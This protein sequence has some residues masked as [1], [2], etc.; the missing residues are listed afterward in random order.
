MG[1][2][3][4]A[5]NSN[6][7]LHQQPNE[8]SGAAGSILSHALQDF[9]SWAWSISSPRYH[10]QAQVESGASGSTTELCIPGFHVF[11]L[12]ASA[13]PGGISRPR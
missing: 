2:V 9:V 13:A 6:L 4:S 8:A 3:D 10:Q 5:A 12:V 7:R 11:G 1:L